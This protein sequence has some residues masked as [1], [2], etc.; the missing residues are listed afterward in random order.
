MHP[1]SYIIGHNLKKI[2]RQAGL[3][4]TTLANHLGISF[5]QI[6]K[7]ENGKNRLPI[8]HIHT[9]K[10]LLG[11]SYDD[12]FT[13]IDDPRNEF[14]PERG[15]P[16]LDAQPIRHNEKIIDRIEKLHQGGMAEKA[17]RILDIL[18]D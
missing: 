14:R 8:D 10:H 12:F 13:A 17:L 16:Y 18:L 5:Q 9:I 15:A 1:I 11:V 3:S 4:Q 2:R 7:Y 6:Q